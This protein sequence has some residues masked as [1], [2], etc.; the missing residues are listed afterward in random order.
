MPTSGDAPAVEVVDLAMRYG[1]VTAVDGLSLRVA[2]GT[3]T[4][5][6]G[7]NGA[8]KTTTIETCPSHRERLVHERLVAQRQQV[9]GH[10]RRRSR[11]GQ[12]VDA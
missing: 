6:L 12:H 2:R 9:E 1:D 4:A 3:V 5:I 11:L 10:E 7:P 8:G